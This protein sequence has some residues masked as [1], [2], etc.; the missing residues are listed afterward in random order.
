MN[1]IPF[2]II[3]SFIFLKENHFFVFLPPHSMEKPHTMAK[4]HSTIIGVYL[5]LIRCWNPIIRKNCLGTLQKKNVN[6]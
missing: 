5:D 6:I 2:M 1:K 4:I 3:I